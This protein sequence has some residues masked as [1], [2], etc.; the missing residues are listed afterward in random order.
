MGTLQFKD[1][2][3]LNTL[4]EGSQVST[5]VNSGTA[6]QLDNTQISVKRG[7]NRDNNP[8]VGSLDYPGTNVGSTNATTYTLDVTLH[9]DDSGDH[10]ILKHL[11]GIDGSSTYPG[12]DRTEGVKAIYP[13]ETDDTR[14]TVPE[15]LGRT[16]T[17]FHTQ[18][19]LSNPA[20][21]VNVVH[22][23][24]NQNFSDNT[25]RVTL[26]CEQA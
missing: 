12:A 21:L 1:L 11:V 4:R 9:N 22:V 19:D 7:S 25:I 18:G 23:R 14:K 13:S 24:V 3:Y 2:G 5:L 20:L 16:G 6:I 8:L 10:T 17:E 15:L 26:E